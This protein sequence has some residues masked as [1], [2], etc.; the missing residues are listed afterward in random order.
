MSALDAFLWVIGA[1]VV[2]CVLFSVMSVSGIVFICLVL[3]EVDIKMM[4]VCEKNQ[5]WLYT[6]GGDLDIRGLIRSLAYAGLPEGLTPKARWLWVYHFK[7]HMY[8]RRLCGH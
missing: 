7:S 3:T 6:A 5:S 2:C 8:Q 4:K 1:A